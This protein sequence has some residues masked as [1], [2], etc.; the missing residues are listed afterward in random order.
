M[1]KSLLRFLPEYFAF[2]VILFSHGLLARDP[3]ARPYRRWI[4]LSS[5]FCCV[6]ILGK[7]PPIHR[8]LPSWIWLDWAQAALMLWSMVAAGT[9]V[10][11]WAAL[12]LSPRRAHSPGRRRLL[13]VAQTAAVAAPAL[14]TGYG[15]FIGRKR[16]QAEEVEIAVAGLP[17]DLHG[18]RIAQ[19]SDMH[20]SNFYSPGDLADAVDL[21]NSYRPHL[22]IASGDLITREGDPLDECI[23]ELGRLRADA[24]VFGCMGNHEVYSDC[25][26]Y[27]QEHA[28]RRGVHFLRSQA[29]TLR[30]G[31][32]RLRLAGVDYQ[33]MRGPYLTN[34]QE[35]QEPGA[36]QLLLS[37]NPDV[38][39]EAAAQG[40]DLTLAGHTHGGQITVEYL[41]QH[42]NVAR[43]FTPYVY[44]HYQ[45]ERAHIY[46]TRGLGT[47]GMP[48][49]ISALPEVALIRLCAT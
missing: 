21:A 36:F 46:V 16:L 34:A 22:S 2:A 5:L 10:G 18:I 44:G 3:V 24:G 17:K 4:L 27:V 9:A 41:H 6:G 38:F 19:L 7:M 47:V 39:D 11:L 37:H 48:A 45:K 12:R 35:L 14:I 29:L 30:F 1:W 13:R 42:L 23:R 8:R 43:F 20:V 26:S 49:R 33:R 40:W 25:E 15:A 32:A 28:A 31:S